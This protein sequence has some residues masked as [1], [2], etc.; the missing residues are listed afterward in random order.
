MRPGRVG[1]RLRDGSATGSA[2]TLPVIISDSFGRAWRNG[3]INVAIG[4][5]GHGAAG[6]LSR[7]DDPHGYMLHAPASWRSRD[8]L[9][10]A[11]EL[12]MGKLDARPVAIVRGYDYRPGAGSGR[13]LLMDPERD[14]FR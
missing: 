8:E 4:V 11:A 12:V 5:A 10:A 13:D 3:I 6:R 9:A 14:L 1:A 2:S 7:P